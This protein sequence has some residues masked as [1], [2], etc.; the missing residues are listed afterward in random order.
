MA[1][2][3][4]AAKT[5]PHASMIFVQLS[6][7]IYVVLSKVI[8]I[9]GISSTVFLAYQFL[10]ASMVM[11]ALALFTERRNRPPLTISILCWIFLLA[12]LGM[13]LSQNLLSACLYYISSTFEATVL[14]MTPI[15]TYVLS[16]VSRQEE[17]K[18][19]TC[20]GKG[21]LFGTLVAVSGAFILVLWKDSSVGLLTTRSLGDFLLGLAMV[22]V[23]VVALSIWI[24]LLRPMTR[25]YPAESSLTAI[26][27]FFGTLQTIVLA[28]ITSREA[29]QWQLQWDL[30]LLNIIFG[31]VFYCGLSNVFTMWC[32]YKKGPI[33]V[34]AFS[35]LSLVFTNILQIL[36]LGDA[37]HVESF[38]GMIVIVVGLYIY[39]WSKAREEK[40]HSMDGDDA[41]TTSLIQNDSA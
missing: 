22:V 36:L 37:L 23:G 39:L 3:F 4:W 29:S 18:F 10:L 15:F 16:I 20:W 14:N 41:I 26:M 30:E 6:T 31:A 1:V 12:L 2:S 5:A 8:L 28:T 24:L 38:I 7:A 27:L 32:A 33:F 19:N 34:S 9:Q 40:Y 17:L 21:K 35:P 25:W 11:G 13:A